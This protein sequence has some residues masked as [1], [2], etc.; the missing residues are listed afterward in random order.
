MKGSTVNHDGISYMLEAPDVME[1]QV[2]HLGLRGVEYVLLCHWDEAEGF[3]LLK[4][5]GS[6]ESW[7]HSSF[8]F[9]NGLRYR[10]PTEQQAEKIIEM[11]RYLE[12]VAY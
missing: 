9:K 12:G 3:V 2:I 5:D 7:E 11:L 4:P 8:V 10:L 6:Q 1:L